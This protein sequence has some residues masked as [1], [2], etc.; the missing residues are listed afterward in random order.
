MFLT[1]EYPEILSE[2]SW[3]MS[4]HE[5][6]NIIHDGDE[7]KEQWLSLFFTRFPWPS[8]DERES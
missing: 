3:E 5:E 6:S 7:E 1:P 2:M 4:V 8:F